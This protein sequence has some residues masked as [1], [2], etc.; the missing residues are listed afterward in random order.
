MST[1]EN[2]DTVRRD[3]ALQVQGKSISKQ[4]NEDVHLVC[5]CIVSIQELPTTPDRLGGRIG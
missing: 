3:Q 5:R 4:Q 1:P 2:R